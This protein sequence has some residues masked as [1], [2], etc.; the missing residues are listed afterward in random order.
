MRVEVEHLSCKI[1]SNGDDIDRDT[2]NV[3]VSIFLELFLFSI[4]C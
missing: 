4:D 2:I 3:F 1:K